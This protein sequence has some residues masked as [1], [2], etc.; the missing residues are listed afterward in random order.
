MFL[1]FVRQ[2]L[3]GGRIVADNLARSNKGASGIDGVSFSAIE[4]EEG[5]VF[6]KQENN[7]DCKNC[8]G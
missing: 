4:A 6:R 1:C 7:Q 2:G 8:A 5:V 3:L